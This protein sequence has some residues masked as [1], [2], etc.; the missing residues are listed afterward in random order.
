MPKSFRKNILKNPFKGRKN[1]IIYLF[2]YILLN[3][4]DLCKKTIA[5]KYSDSHSG[6]FINVQNPKCL[7]TF[8]SKNMSSF[9]LVPFFQFKCVLVPFFQFNLIYIPTTVTIRSPNA[10]I[11]TCS[12]KSTSIRCTTSFAITW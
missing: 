6:H 12:G 10:I 11:W 7:P 1:R 3:N 8:N 5:K 2:S 4:T 9:F